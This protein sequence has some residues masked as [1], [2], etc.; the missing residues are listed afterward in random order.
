[1]PFF[2]CK[3]QLETESLKLDPID[4]LS[5]PGLH[6]SSQDQ[7][8]LCLGLVPSSIVSLQSKLMRKMNGVRS[9][10]FFQVFHFT[11]CGVKK[12]DT[13]GCMVMPLRDHMTTSPA[14]FHY[15]MYLISI[16]VSFTEFSALQ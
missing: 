5:L 8:Q 4:S 6:N 1:M 12:F 15:S 9:P 2:F 10:V 3:S 14:V 13:S 7:W 11:A 16:L